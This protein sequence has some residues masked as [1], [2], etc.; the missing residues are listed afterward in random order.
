MCFRHR[1]GA[2]PPSSRSSCEITG[3]ALLQHFCYAAAASS[4]VLEGSHGLCRR[5]RSGFDI[6]W[7]P[8]YFRD[9]R[10]VAE[11]ILRSC[12]QRHLRF[13]LFGACTTFMP[14]AAA[15]A[16]LITPI[17]RHR[18]DLAASCP[19]IG[20]P[21][22]NHRKPILPFVSL[23]SCRPCP[24]ARAGPIQMFVHSPISAS[25]HFSER[26]RTRVDRIGVRYSAAEMISI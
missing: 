3:M 25:A 24:I 2:R 13:E 9:R 18:G 5:R 20:R 4:R 22:G 19:A 16:A 7:M 23:R 21:T 17:A 8:R 11:R 14:P 6:A 12:G 10:F 1:L 26:I 15:H